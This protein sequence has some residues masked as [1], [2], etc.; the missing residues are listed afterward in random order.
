MS[1]VQFLQE[2][3]QQFRRRQNRTLLLNQISRWLFACIFI[4]LS[5]ATIGY[6]FEFAALGWQTLFSLWAFGVFV[7]S[8]FTVLKIQ[9]NLQSESHFIHYLEQQAPDLQQRLLTSMEFD[10]ANNS[11]GVSEQFVA[12]LWQDAKQ[13]IESSKPLESLEVNQTAWRSIGLAAL[14]VI[15][16]I[17][18]LNI[19]DG[20]LQAS[21]QFVWPW[22]MKTAPVVVEVPEPVIPISIEVTPGDVSLQRG[23]NLEITAALDNAT[24]D[25]LSLYVQTDNVTWRRYT[26]VPAASQPNRD[27]KLFTIDLPRLMDDSVYYVAYESDRYESEESGPADAAPKSAQYQV[28]LFDL[29]QVESMAVAYDFPDY[30]RLEDKV[31]DPGGDVVAPE[32]TT[33]DLDI[34]LNKAVKEGHIQFEDGSVVALDVDGK[35]ARGSFVVEKDAYYSIELVDI[36]D[37]KNTSSGE[38]Y[39]RAIPDEAPEIV[40]QKPGRDQDVMPLEEVPIAID[41][42]DDYGVT[43]FILNYS[44]IG[45]DE[46]NVDFLPEG[47][48][49]KR[50]TGISTP[51]L[52]QPEN[53]SFRS[54]VRFT[55]ETLLYLE[56]LAVQPGDVVSFS[57]TAADNNELN[58]ASRTVSDIYFLEVTST[59]HEFSRANAGGGGGGGG[60]GDNSTALVTNQ[61]DVISAT[62]KLKNRKDKVSE[63]SFSADGD[64]IRMSQEEVAQRAQ[65]SINRLTERGDYENDA[66]DRAVQALQ[67]AIVDM[68]AAVTSLTEMSL[69][70]ALMAEQKALQSILR[71]EAQ[72]NKTQVTMNR[73]QSSGGGGGGQQEQEDLRELFEM[74]MG[75]LENRYE[76]PQQAQ[77]G[78]Q[79]QSNNEL[80]DRLK[81]LAR[82]Q[83]RIARA[84][85]ELSRRD[86]D[87]EQRRR[88]LEQLRRQ[89]E[90]LSRDLQQ[91]AQQ[92]RQQEGGQ[93]QS[94]QQQSSQQQSQ[95]SSSQQPG[96]QS[97]QQQAGQPSGGQQSGS[98]QS[99]SQQSGGQQSGSPQNQSAQNQGSQTQ[100]LQQAVEQMQQAANA[101]TAG[102]AAAKA[103]KAL[104]SLREQQ[105]QWQQEGEQSV[106]D[107][108]RAMQQQAQQLVS[109][110]QQ[111]REQIE[112]AGRQ[113]NLGNSRSENLQQ[114][115]VAELL[116]AQQSQREKLQELSKTLRGVTT[117]ADED[118]RRL[119]DQAHEA[120]LALKPIED[121]M[122]T[123]EQILRRGMVNL[124]L[125]LEQEIESELVTLRQQLQQVGSGP[126]R[127]V[128]NS[129]QQVANQVRQLR[130]SLENLQEQANNFQQP[131]ELPVSEGATNP[132]GSNSENAQGGN[133]DQ[134]GTSREQMQQTLAQAQQQ[135]Q[136]LLR[137]GFGGRDLIVSARSIKQ[138]LSQTEIDEFLSRPELL[139]GLLQPL[140]EMENKLRLQ[141]EL[142]AIDNRLYSSL[143]DDVPE[144]Y[145]NLVE[146]YYRQLSDKNVS[147]SQS[148]GRN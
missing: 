85:R 124:S 7:A 79:Q 92:A 31:E 39:V 132:N 16:F 11:S 5:L 24:A 102:Q 98:Q 145:K 52:I 67:N 33:I 136:G 66:Y 19:S 3:V 54:S 90:E 44:V 69:A 64:V 68:K 117:Q 43:E 62:W 77:G 1:A 78:G 17:T 29:P 30:T 8:I 115:G 13:H 61:K 120:S 35:Q 144:E 48:K 107:M 2:R 63:E 99:G 113:Q 65:M 73:S 36:E 101:E 55:G 9:N 82:R 147:D 56:D 129:E 93:Q 94:G 105:Q 130:R 133:G 38:Y 74:E 122:N 123:S 37:N 116:E 4:F 100:Q 112:E 46:V 6:I 76:L 26:M 137:S 71:A 134:P 125:K 60:G 140:M 50:Y 70:E 110:Q 25:V 23:D 87:E 40:L 131:G 141:S 49:P 15:G 96:Q 119:M 138:E 142:N 45:A 111:L 57:V 14:S 104:E 12:R 86:L 18:V 21:R 88:Q 146:T 97:S 83:E 126:S 22:E 103:Q 53:N 139:R 95:N 75:E 72:I 10:S 51:K 106:A 32:G 127:S 91:L 118:Q 81:E 47:G 27:A 89:Q 34:T 108:Q 41:V 109:G 121:K 128:A 143:D 58:G 80:M 114:D 84:Q 20:F 59:D 135:A 28:A 148:D 42:S